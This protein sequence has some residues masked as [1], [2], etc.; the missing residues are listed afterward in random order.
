MIEVQGA[1]PS[2]KL[3]TQEIEVLQHGLAI[4]YVSAAVTSCN[5]NPSLQVLEAYQAFYLWTVNLNLNV[6]VN[7][8][9][10]IYIVYCIVYC[11]IYIYT[12]LTFSYNMAPV[13]VSTSVSKSKL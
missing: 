1:S 9:I 8:Y 10:Y 5:K 12:H 7:I 6:S 3:F 4:P 13:L 11:D 2:A